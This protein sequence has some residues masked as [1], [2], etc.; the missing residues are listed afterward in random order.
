MKLLKEIPQKILKEKIIGQSVYESSREI[1]DYLNYSMRDLKKEVFKVIYLNNQ[2]QIM[3]TADLFEGTLETIPIRPREITED[4]LK[5]QA[6]ALMFAHNH[7]SG[8][9]SPSESDKQVTRDLVFMGNIL[10]SR[11]DGLRNM[12]IIS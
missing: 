1:F 9:P 10:Q 7:P 12:K 4:A 8:D 6:T 3:D 2:N 11:G 5:H